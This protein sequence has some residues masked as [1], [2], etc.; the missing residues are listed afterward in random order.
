MSEKKISTNT[1]ALLPLLSFTVKTNE[2]DEKKPRDFTRR[3]R[4]RGYT[5]KQ[6]RILVDWFMRVRKTMA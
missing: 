5:D 6:I 3:M 4:D 1:E 2:E